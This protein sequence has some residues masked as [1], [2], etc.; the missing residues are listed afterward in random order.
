MARPRTRRHS[1]VMDPDDQVPEGRAV[2]T[3]APWPVARQ[4]TIPRHADERT[5]LSASLDY[6]RE[7]IEMKCDGVPPQRLSERS[8]PPSTMSLHGLVRHLAGVERWWFAVNFAGLELPLLYYSDDDPDQDFESLDGNPLEALEV[9]RSE[10]QRSREIV[11]RASGLDDRGALARDGSYTLR[12]L[13]LRL[14]GEYAQHAGHADLLRQ[15]ID[16]ATGI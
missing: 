6:H 4:V 12:W 11:E 15:G 10:C 8:C 13:L 9:W 1:G 2:V 5:M 14:I 3:P 16:G 7:S